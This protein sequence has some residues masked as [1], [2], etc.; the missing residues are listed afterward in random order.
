MHWDRN[1]NA[2]A[3]EVQTSVDP[4]TGTSFATVTTVTKSKALL[5]GLT[6]GAKIWVRVRAIGTAG[7]GGWSD[8][9]GTFVP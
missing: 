5:T 9:A 3:Y 4:I 2:N 8:P 1:S 7:N 6:S